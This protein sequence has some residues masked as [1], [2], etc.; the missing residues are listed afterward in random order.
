MFRTVYKLLPLS[1]KCKKWIKENVSLKDWQS[2]NGIA[3][4]WRYV[5]DIVEG[6]EVDGI[7]IDKDFILV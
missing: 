4:E 5:D 2:P 7:K 1:R 3:I 6:L